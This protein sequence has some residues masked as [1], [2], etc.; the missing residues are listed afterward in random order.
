VLLAW[1]DENRSALAAF[2]DEL[3]TA[4]HGAPP[5]A[6]LLRRAAPPS[7]HPFNPSRSSQDQRLRELNTPSGSIFVKETPRFHLF[8]PAV[9][10]VLPECA[11]FF[12]KRSLFG[13]YEK[14]VFRLITELPL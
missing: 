9:L 12:G 3:H 13:L 7:S 4:G 1:R 8:E 6:H 5:R 11:F 2:S 10:G 14:Y